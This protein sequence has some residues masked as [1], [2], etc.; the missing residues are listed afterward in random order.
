MNRLRLAIIVVSAMAMGLM[1]A[2]GGEKPIDVKTLMASAETLC[3]VPTPARC[4][5]W[6]TMIPG[7]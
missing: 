4:A 2:C 6:S 3:R 1:V 5:T 7:R